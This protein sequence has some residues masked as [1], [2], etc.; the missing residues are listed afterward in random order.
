MPVDGNGDAESSAHSVCTTPP[1]CQG[2]AQ[3]PAAVAAEESDE[4]AAAAQPEPLRRAGVQFDAS[5]CMYDVIIA[6]VE[7]R[8]WKVVRNANKAAACNVHWVDESG[9]ADAFQKVQPWMR[10]NHFPGTHNALARKSRLARNMARMQRLF[11][12]EY[13]FLPD[14][15]VLPDDA[16]ELE[17]QFDDTGQSKSI[18]IAKPDAG[19]QGRGIFLTNRLD[20]LKQ[21]ATDRD[22]PLVVQRYIRKPMLIE[23]LKFDLR[24]YFLL[25]GVIDEAGV[26]QPRY[27][28]MH[29][30]LVRLCTTEYVEPS[31]DNLDKKRM[32]LTNYA[33]NKK[34]KDF[35]QNDGDDD[36]AGSKR[37]LRW[38]ME[39]IAEEYGEKER[40]KLW[41]KLKGL[42]VK[43]ALAAHPSLEAEYNNLLP[44]DLSAGAF[45]CRCFELL[46][47][48][49]MLDSKRRPVLIEINHL[50]SFQCDSP[51]DED[52]KSRAIQQTLDLTCP[53]DPGDRQAYEAAV[54]ARKQADGAA[55]V[56]A[57][58]GNDLL[59]CEWYGDFERVY[60]GHRDKP[61][62]ALRFETI[63]TRV[64][65][66]FRPV[67]AGARGA[68]KPARH[69]APCDMGPVKAPAASRPPR[70]PQD[71]AKARAL[72]S[73]PVAGGS[74]H[75]ASRRSGSAPARSARASP[76]LP[77]LLVSPSASVSSLHGGASPRSAAAGHVVRARRSASHEA[78]AK[79][80]QHEPQRE[81]VAVRSMQLIL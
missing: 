46:G 38:F 55:G 53:C 65:E 15:W 41:T 12:A 71:S 39:Y 52:I 2:R 36:G 19:T 40:S 10:I 11:P 66:V 57:Y 9:V 68:A 3:H 70:P 44:K 17:R 14:S 28:L 33:I 54:L 35:V 45:G 77:A 73:L 16:G 24:L 23:G 5:H 67:H 61:K 29:D 7:S 31:L 47:V 76:E 78:S 81:Q 18:F 25:A 8:G 80:R 22:G 50:P 21:V 58:V 48:D 20:R 69:T 56:P 49:V 34:S 26:L 27:Y 4:A 6:E 59:N 63:L 37:A 74:R 30:G 64:R 42:C 13:N 32:H 62:A 75:S 79:R 60:P 1:P 51:L 43:V 72:V